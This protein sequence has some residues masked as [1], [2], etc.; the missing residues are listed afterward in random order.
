[1]HKPGAVKAVGTEAAGEVVSA[2]AEVQNF[3]VGDRVMGRMA[4][5]HAYPSK[6]I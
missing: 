3:A 6:P 1:M 4:G 5:A 2:G